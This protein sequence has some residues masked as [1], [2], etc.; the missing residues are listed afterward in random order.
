M[1]TDVRLVI[2]SAY[3]SR[4]VYALPGFVSLKYINFAVD[5]DFNEAFK[6][7]LVLSS[8]KVLST[9]LRSI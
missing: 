1:I 3:T 2:L 8:W 9:P 6:R 5:S 7:H 4:I